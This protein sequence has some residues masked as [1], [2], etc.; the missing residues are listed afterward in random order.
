MIFL[1][2]LNGVVSQLFV[3]DDDLSL[4]PWFS[5]EENGSGVQIF[6]IFVPY[7]HNKQ[8]YLPS[9]L[10]LYYLKTSANSLTHKICARSKNER[11][12][13]FGW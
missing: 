12:W 7:L 1:K 5:N 13:T 3:D 10:R 4:F 11:W 9:N 2:D 8:W 6:T